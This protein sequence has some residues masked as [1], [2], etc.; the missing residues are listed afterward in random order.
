MSINPSNFV[1]LL[2]GLGA[3]FSSWRARFLGGGALHD[4]VLVIH[5]I[6]EFYHF[7]SMLLGFV[8]S[9]GL[10]DQIAAPM[11]EVFRERAQAEHTQ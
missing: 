1:L 2:D 6:F 7:D 8:S 11:A 4:D 3:S 5:L 10:H 9:E